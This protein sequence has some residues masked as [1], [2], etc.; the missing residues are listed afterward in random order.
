MD[1][2]GTAQ[3][4]FAVERF[5]HEKDLQD[6][7]V[8]NKP[9]PYRTFLYQLIGSYHHSKKDFKQLESVYCELF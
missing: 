6:Q 5:F 8:H 3:F 2:I 1:F 4:Q 7:D 9:R